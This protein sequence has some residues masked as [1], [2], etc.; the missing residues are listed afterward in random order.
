[1]SNVE[2]EIYFQGGGRSIPD[3]P[4]SPEIDADSVFWICS[5]TK[6]IAAV[7][8]VLFISVNNLND[9]VDFWTFQRVD[10]SAQAHRSWKA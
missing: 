2:G 3:D 1:M 4:Q 10:R 9:Q 7:S 6:M 5:Q 8:T